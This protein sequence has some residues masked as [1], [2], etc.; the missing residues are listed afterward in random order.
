MNPIT[1]Q[2]VEV[3]KHQGWAT[4]SRHTINDL[5]PHPE[6]P[7]FKE[8]DR[9][10]RDALEHNIKPPPEQPTQAEQIQEFC[11]ANDLIFEDRPDNRDVVVFMCKG[12][13]RS[14]KGVKKDL[15]ECKI[16]E[17]VHES[18]VPEHARQGDIV[19]M[20][21]PLIFNSSFY[22]DV[23]ANPMAAVTLDVF[24]FQRTKLMNGE[25]LFVRIS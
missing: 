25:S 15:Q 5:F 23:K 22:A 14:M 1:E 6:S 11:D 24:T 9:M 12:I 8:T 3:A 7:S 16:G 21:P 18:D 20:A 2:I 13:P 19:K 17:G 4:V 10:I